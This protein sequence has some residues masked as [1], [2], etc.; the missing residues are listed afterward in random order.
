MSSEA[1][2][3]ALDQLGHDQRLERFGGLALHAA[4][5]VAAEEFA[6][7][8]DRQEIGGDRRGEILADV[9]VVGG[10]DHRVAAVDEA[11]GMEAGEGAER[12]GFV[13]AD[14]TALPFVPFDF[15]VP[16]R[17][18]KIATGIVVILA[19]SGADHSNMPISK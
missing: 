14:N 4:Q 9:E 5:D 3:G 13:G 12:G 8:V 10:V 1:V 15:F 16:G 2:V 7:L 11:A 17:S 19:E 18:L 6:R